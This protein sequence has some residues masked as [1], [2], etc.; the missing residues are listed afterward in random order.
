MDDLVREGIPWEHAVDLTTG[1]DAACSKPDGSG[2]DKRR[3]DHPLIDPKTRG[4]KALAKKE[5]LT[6]EGREKW[7]TLV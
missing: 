3:E 5:L 2:E 4:S 7:R 6:E 1:L